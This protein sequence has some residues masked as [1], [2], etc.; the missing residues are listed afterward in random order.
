MSMSTHPPSAARGRAHEPAPGELRIRERRSWRTW[1]LIVGLAIALVVGMVIGNSGGRN[2]APVTNAYTLPAPAGSPDS[3]SASSPSAAASVSATTKASAAGTPTSTVATSAAVP[4]TTAPGPSTTLPAAS[5][6]PGT[7]G[8]P[9]AG[10][11]TSIVAGGQDYTVGPAAPT[12]TAASAAAPAGG[13]LVPKAQASGSWSTASFTVSSGSWQVGWAYS[14][15][16]VRAGE[17]FQIYVLSAGGKAT[18]EPI[19]QQWTL[20][21]QG[22]TSADVHGTLTLQIEAN[23]T[24]VSAVKVVAATS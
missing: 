13:V 22:V 6:P 21:D 17:A 9:T 7:G 8:G 1:Q 18:P 10:V 19:V 12:I 4:T 15:S 2:A 20:A 14:C 23:E 16:G 11:S 24:C 3:P 5:E